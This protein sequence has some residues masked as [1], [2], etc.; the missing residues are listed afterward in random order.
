MIYISDS[1][2]IEP[3]TLSLNRSHLRKI[4]GTGTIHLYLSKKEF[5]P[6]KVMFTHG[7]LR[8]SKIVFSMFYRN[9]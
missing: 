1:P 3:Y 7:K 6:L 4:N 2:N 8:K 5:K 9:I